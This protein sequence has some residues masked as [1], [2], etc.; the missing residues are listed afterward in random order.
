[1]YTQKKHFAHILIVAVISPVLGTISDIMRGKKRFLA[2][3]AGIGILSTGLLVL[4]ETGDWAAPTAEYQR[5][6]KLGQDAVYDVIRD[7]NHQVTK[8]AGLE[9]II[10]KRCHLVGGVFHPHILASARTSRG[11][12]RIIRPRECG[13][14]QF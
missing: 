6:A 4:V 7:I 12:R 5:R 10:S 8:L 13:F 1:M 14:C 11:H 3:F 9:A 2:V